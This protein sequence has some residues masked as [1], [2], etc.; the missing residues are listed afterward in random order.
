MIDS[1]MLVRQNMDELMTMDLPTDFIAAAHACTCNPNHIKHYPA[2]WIPAN[3]AH[4]RATTFAPLPASSFVLKEHHKINSGL[5]VLRPSL[6]TMSD[7][8]SHLLTH[9]DVVKY[10]FPDQDLIAAMWREKLVPLCWKYNALKTLRHCH[11]TVWRDDV[12]KNVHYILDKPW[13]G[14]IHGRNRIQVNAEVT[15]GWWWKEWEE[16]LE[17]W[18]EKPG[19]AMVITTVN[20]G[21]A[22]WEAD[23]PEKEE[24]DEK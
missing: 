7:I 24:K 8:Q 4:T 5:V 14:T 20:S 10:Q 2:S 11:E 15:H 19:R 16:L 23:P 12:V 9:P 22:P 1:D 21:P 3:C 13:K 18:G 17:G 6:S